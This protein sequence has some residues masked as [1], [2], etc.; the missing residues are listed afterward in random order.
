[1][2]LLG[3]PPQPAAT[4]TIASVAPAMVSHRLT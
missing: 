3:L 4:M 2:E 1:V